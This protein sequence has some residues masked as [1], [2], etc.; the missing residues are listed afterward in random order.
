MGFLRVTKLFL[1]TVLASTLF[2]TFAIDLHS[3]EVDLNS[4]G[5]KNAV[6]NER[7]SESKKVKNG[8]RKNFT[9]QKSKEEKVAPQEGSQ[10]TSKVIK[11]YPLLERVRA[12]ISTKPSLSPMVDLKPRSLKDAFSQPLTIGS[13]AEGFV[14]PDWRQPFKDIQADRMRRELESGKTVL[15]GSV[16]LK[17]G[18]LFFRS[19]KFTY[20]EDIGEI[21]A[22]GNVLIT[23]K[24]AELKANRIIYTTPGAEDIS[25]Y[26][27][28]FKPVMSE[29]EI[30]KKRLT[31]GR[32]YAEQLSIKDPLRDF[33][34]GVID[35]NLLKNTGYLEDAK[36]QIGPFYFRAGRL[37][38]KGRD[39]FSAEDVWITT[40]DKDPPHYRI[41]VRSLEV[42]ESKFKKAEYLR[43]QVGRVTT[44]LFLPLWFGEGSALGGFDFDIGRE[45]GIGGYINVGYQH[46]L[47]RNVSL[48]PRIML[49]EEE[50]VGFGGDIL[51]DFMDEPTSFFYRTKGEAQGLYTTEDRGYIHI[52][53]RFEPSDDLIFIS[54]LEHWSDEDFYKDFFYKKYRDRTEPRTFLNVTYRQPEYILT[55]TARIGTHGWVHETERLPEFT[56]HWLE[57]PLTESLYLSFDTFT[58][59]NR[60]EV[61]EYDALRTV[62]ILRLTYDLRSLGP[63]KITP[64][65]ETQVN[66]YSKSVNEDEGIGGI[67]QKVGVTLQTRL[68]RV[69][70]SFLDFSSVKHVIVPSLTLSYRT[71]SAYNIEDRYY[72]D[73]LDIVSGQM[74]IE[75]KIEN[76][77]YGKD[78][79]SQEVWQIARITFY[80]GNDF[81]N[82]YHK[83]DDY[84]LEIDIRPRIWYG[85]QLVAEKHVGEDI[86]WYE[87]LDNHRLDSRLREKVQ[88]WFWDKNEY[89]FSRNYDLIFGDYSR[90]LGLFYFDNT[91]MGGKYNG[92]IGYMLA[93]T[94]DDVFNK[95]ILYGLG[96]KIS[97]KWSVAFEHIYDLENG[98]MRRQTYEIRRNL[99]CWDLGIRWTERERG[100]DISVEFSLTAFPGTR[101][102]F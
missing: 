19:D 77:F 42:E 75:S 1:V 45:S 54:Q 73:P 96:Y 78:A 32:I 68:V 22:E 66:W 82:E 92:R 70:G 50:G 41:K 25:K 18:E 7:E 13:E 6:S 60:R 21:M 64:F 23:Q 4:N 88:E 89:P 62:N 90:V 97:D 61:Y 36:G 30:A 11:R 12:P 83:S 56:F 86:K 5:S 63:I 20:T 93:E 71:P 28:I 59:Y 35:F 29:E 39:T 34:A 17:F 74:R 95:D 94:E 99:H 15:E 80:Q 10:T 33:Y 2:L 16:R 102:R 67:S 8:V 76:I 55:G 101:I 72:F 87:I 26:P 48:G 53:H 85:L 52:K 14:P 37:E 46:E 81:W 49:T 9:V 47:G 40:C 98:D 31:T 84:E 58:G 91:I 43:L 44:P 51:W 3:V 65:S 79:E 69:F 27:Q 100:T 38:I 24:E 57:H